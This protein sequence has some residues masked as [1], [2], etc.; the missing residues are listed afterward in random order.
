MNSFIVIGGGILGASTAYHLA[1][2]GAEVTLV[3]RRDTGQATSA[4][5]GIICP[6]L[7]QRRNKP[8]YRLVKAGARYYPELIKQLEDVNEKNTGYAKVGALSLHH[9]T[10]KLD[11]ME[12][13]AIKRREDAPEI[14]E[15]TRLSPLEARRHFPLL[16][17]GYG[18][19]HVSGGARVDGRALR[20]SLLKA[21]KKLG[22]KVIRDNASLI[23]ENSQVTGVTVGKTKLT[24]DK[25]ILTEGAWANDLL[26]KLNIK[27][28]VK[29]QKGQIVHLKLDIENSG[30]PVV[31]PPNDY[32]LLHFGEGRVVIGATRENDKG[33][34]SRV[35]AGGLEEVF[36]EAFTFAPGLADGE[37]LETRVG[38]RPFTPGFLPVIGAVPDVE[39]LLFANGLGASGLT[40]GP[41][42]GAELARL[43][44]GSETE[45]CLEDYNVAGAI[46]KLN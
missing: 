44:L 1:L 29:P 39:R 18:A 10:N 7:S 40:S 15:I 36:R 23:V 35:T 17:E 3:D 4:G 25:V 6:W 22:V 30:W 5:A 21:A 45:L 38:F 9:D 8:W 19:V 27:V 11:K 31:I 43:A 14:G 46:E 32:Y 2:K 41:F 34:D 28:L 42:L 12:E 24:S 33:F 13:R 16:A 37:V 20:D 26:Q